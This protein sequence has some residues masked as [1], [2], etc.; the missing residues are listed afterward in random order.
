MSVP[1]RPHDPPAVVERNQQVVLTTP[2]LLI[3]L[4]S[5]A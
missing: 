5:H 2:P 3:A 1:I 4:R